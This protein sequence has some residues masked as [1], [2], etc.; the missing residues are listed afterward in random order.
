VQARSLRRAHE[1][2]MGFFGHFALSSHHRAENK[3]AQEGAISIG[4]ARRAFG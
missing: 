2:L 3:S 4:L 1:L